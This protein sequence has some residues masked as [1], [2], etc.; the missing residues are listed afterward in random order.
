MDNLYGHLPRT[1][2][3][4]IPPS[5][6]ILPEGE[7]TDTPSP[8]ILPEGETNDSTASTTDGS[9]KTRRRSRHKSSSP[10]ELASF[11]RSRTTPA[12]PGVRKKHSR[13][14]NQPPPDSQYTP[15]VTDSGYLI[16]NAPKGTPSV[17]PKRPDTG[18]G[19]IV[20]LSLNSDPN[21]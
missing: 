6:V 1:T 9:L 19:G 16:T 14:K 21:P 11:V 10:T 7:T 15:L 5:P 8:L 3:S 18:V 2:H 13:A 12:L 4:L 17:R 20:S